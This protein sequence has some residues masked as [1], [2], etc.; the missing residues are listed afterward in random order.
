LTCDHLK[1]HKKKFILRCLNAFKNYS[2]EC[3][4]RAVTKDLKNSTES[5]VWKTNAYQLRRLERVKFAL[6]NTWYAL[7]DKPLLLV[8]RGFL[9]QLPFGQF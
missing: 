5:P 6:L 2:P 7:G 9:Q 3:H 4:G 8:N 1:E